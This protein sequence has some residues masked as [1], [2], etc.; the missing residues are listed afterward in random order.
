M[1]QEAAHNCVKY[2]R[3]N[4]R[5]ARTLEE[6]DART[7]GGFSFIHSHIVLQH[8][9]PQRGLSIISALLSRLAA[10]AVPVAAE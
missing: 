8:L 2:N 9:D 6:I 1:L 3:H 7:S 5:L 4:V 10:D